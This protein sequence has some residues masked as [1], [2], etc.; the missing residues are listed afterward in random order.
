[1]WYFY[2]MHVINALIRSVVLFL[3]YYTLCNAGLWNK[4]MLNMLRGDTAP[5]VPK[6]S[7]LVHIRLGQTVAYTPAEMV[8]RVKAYEARK[9]VYDRTVKVYSDCMSFIV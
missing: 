9:A 2:S 4:W 8:V 1:M 7:P 5:A 3:T 6:E